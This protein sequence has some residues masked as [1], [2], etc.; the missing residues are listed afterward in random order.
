VYVD[1]QPRLT[2]SNSGTGPQ[3]QMGSAVE[4]IPLAQ[5]EGMLKQLTV[6]DE[7]R[8]LPYV[9][10]IEEGRLVASA[11]SVVHVRGLAN[12]RPGMAVQLARPVAE[13]YQGKK[14]FRTV[15]MGLDFRGQWLRDEWG[16]AGRKVGVAR[17]S[18]RAIGYELMRHSQGEVTQVQGEIAVVVLREEGRDVRIGDRVLPV[19]TQPYDPYFYP[20][21]PASVPEHAKIMAVADGHEFS[22]PR[23]VV[24]ISAGAADGIKNGATFSLWHDG[25]RTHDLVRH[26]YLAAAD[27]RKVTLPD[28]YV[29]RVMV[30][31]TFNRMSY[32]LVMESIR[33]TQVGDMLKHPDATQ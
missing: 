7:I 22:G 21:A 2:S 31:R 1:G 8:S 26:R 28:D 5:V 3:P 6:V 29:G 25:P 10:G 23:Q 16:T 15:G 18:E 12:A 9:I 20:Q 30:F 14:G 33:P 27:Q 13:Y 24:A 32:G 4:T 19:E 17:R 11:G